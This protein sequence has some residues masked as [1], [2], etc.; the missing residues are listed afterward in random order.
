MFIATFLLFKYEGGLLT[1]FLVVLL[2]PAGWFLFWEGL[3][4]TIFSS[5]KIKPD[6]NFYEKMSKCY[7]TFLSY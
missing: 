7:I 3:D 5:K 2:E 1:S 6:L 4:L